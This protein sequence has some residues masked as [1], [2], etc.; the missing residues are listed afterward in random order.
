[1]TVIA[2]S[3]IFFSAWIPAFGLLSLR[4]VATSVTVAIAFAGI[5]I[6]SF[7]AL[8][9]LL[10]A[11]RRVSPTNLVLRGGESQS[12]QVTSFLLAYLL[13][14]VIPD[15]SDSFTVTA[16]GVFFVLLWVLYVRGHLVL[17]P[18]LLLLG[19]AIWRADIGPED[20]S[21]ETESVVLIV[22]SADLRVGDRLWVYQVDSPI[23][24]AKR[25]T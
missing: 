24:I 4:A 9:I 11:F 22:D 19:W 14:F 6:V 16:L 3:I 25:A 18:V 2:R 5:A 12:E 23:R 20:S 21:N 1:M 17:N 8:V 7:I 15:Y 10:A 13:P